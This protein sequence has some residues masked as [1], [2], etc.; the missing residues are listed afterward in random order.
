MPTI[1]T[2]RYGQVLLG[3]WRG[4][5]VAVKVLRETSLHRPNT[6]ALDEFRQEAAILQSL[7]HPNILMFYGACF[8]CQPV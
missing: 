3:R 4:A 7:R 2:L 8:N 5:L 1:V 6:G